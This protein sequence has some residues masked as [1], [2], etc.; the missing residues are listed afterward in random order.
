VLVWN[1]G[2]ID[3]ILYWLEVKNYIWGLS[4]TTLDH[5]EM[6][7]A[8]AGL[9][10]EGGFAWFYSED[11]MMVWTEAEQLYFFKK[12]GT[13]LPP[14]REVSYHDLG[15]ALVRRLRTSHYMENISEDATDQVVMPPMIKP[16]VE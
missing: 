2:G 4:Q 11:E 3:G 12:N 16:K 5:E 14:A 15:G 13:T 8:M 6:L 1:D 10:D 7:S 9:L